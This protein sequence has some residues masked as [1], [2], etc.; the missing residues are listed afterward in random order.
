M[1][2]GAAYVLLFLVVFMLAV[3]ARLPLRWALP[4]LPKSVRCERP[5]GSLWSGACHGLTLPTPGLSVAEFEWDLRPASL[6]HLK[7][8]ADI[9]A[10]QEDSSLT[11]VAE[12]AAG[13]LEF[14][15]LQGRVRLGPGMPPPLSGWSGQ[16][17]LHAVRVRIGSGRLDR[18]DGRFEAHD[19]RSPQGTDWGAFSLE[20]APVGLP[21]TVAPGRLASIGGPIRAVGLVQLKPAE[22][23]WQLELK[24]ALR[25][26]AAPDLERMLSALGPPDAEGLRP[27]SVAGAY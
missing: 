23:S 19:L 16:V 25:P 18:L 4:L 14:R 15:G 27:L 10:A 9:R 8:S 26:G 6:L 24:V 5:E 3:A 1:R 17:A 2:R 12:W 22:R 7:P 11:G 20:F 13:R 21:G